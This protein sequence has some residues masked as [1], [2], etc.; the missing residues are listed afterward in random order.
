MTVF[1][2][3]VESVSGVETYSCNKFEG[4]SA[5]VCPLWKP[6]SQQKM[7]RDER[8]CFYLLEYQKVDSEATFRGAGLGY[9][10]KVMAETTDEIYARPDLHTNL[11]K[12][13]KK[14]ANTSSKIQAGRTLH[15]DKELFYL[16][17]SYDK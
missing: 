5:P 2:H 6:I 11:I 12:A 1:P 15:L 9:Y 7:R 14:A 4:C 8:A 17:S 10:F 13:L 16:E 3:I